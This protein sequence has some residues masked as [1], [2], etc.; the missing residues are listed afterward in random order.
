MMSRTLEF[1]EVH[2]TSSKAAAVALGD[3]ARTLTEQYRRLGDLLDE[4][5]WHRFDTVTGPLIGGAVILG[6]LLLAALA[7]WGG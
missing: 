7:A 5:R 6:T 3:A 4:A 2:L 1:L